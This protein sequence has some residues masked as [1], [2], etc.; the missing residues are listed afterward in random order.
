MGFDINVMMTMYTCPESGKPYYLKWSKEAKNYEKRYDLPDIIVPEKMCKYLVGRGH[1]F[2]AYTSHF[3]ELERYDV[4][5]E[6]FLEQYPSWDE[7]VDDPSY[8][9]ECGWFEEDHEG[10]KRVLEWCTQQCV[11]FRVSW[12][13]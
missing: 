9:D 12:S 13:Y 7:L 4:T 6:E 10:F 11:S 2:H 1:H 3:N 8:E 5:V